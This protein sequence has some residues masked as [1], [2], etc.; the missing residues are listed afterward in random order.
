[1]SF[2]IE[3]FDKLQKQLKKMEKGARELEKNNQI[4][5][6]DLFTISFMSKYTNFSSFDELLEAGNFIVNSQEDFEAIPD[7]EFDMHISTN[8]SFKKWEDMLAK[9]TEI[10]VAKKLGL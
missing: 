7:A 3:G 4:P 6:D 8:T 2:K 1:M 9:A 10:Y 5:F